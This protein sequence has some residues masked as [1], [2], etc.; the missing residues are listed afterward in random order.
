M[1]VGAE[2]RPW[3]QPDPAYGVTARAPSRR[4]RAPDLTARAV[5]SGGRP[6]PA[7][8][9]RRAISEEG[10]A[11][12]RRPSSSHKPSAPHHLIYGSQENN[13]QHC[14]QRSCITMTDRIHCEAEKKAEQSAAA[15]LERCSRNFFFIFI[16]KNK[17]K[18]F[19]LRKKYFFYF[20][21]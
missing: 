21:L 15:R 2:L 16:N 9:G 1:R 7:G 11:G 18:Y 20:Y 12:R 14:I 10:G 19:L 17:K 8:A 13:A 5:K 6:A 4:K 3:S